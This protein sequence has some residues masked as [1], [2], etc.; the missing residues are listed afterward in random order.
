MKLYFKCFD[1]HELLFT[2]STNYLYLSKRKQIQLKTLILTHSDAQTK[3]LTFQRIW[4]L[5]KFLNDVI[6]LSVSHR[7]SKPCLVVLDENFHS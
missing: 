6:N 2:W 3:L 4:L 7:K 1:R 5:G